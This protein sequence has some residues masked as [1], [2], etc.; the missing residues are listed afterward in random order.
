MQNIT[1]YTKLTQKIILR[2]LQFFSIKMNIGLKP[3]NALV[4][5]RQFTNSCLQGC[6]F[7]Y[8]DYG[9]RIIKRVLSSGFSR[10]MFLRRYWRTQHLYKM[11]KQTEQFVVHEI[12]RSLSSRER[13]FVKCVAFPLTSSITLQQ[14]SLTLQSA[15]DTAFPFQCAEYYA[16]IE[17]CLK[18]L[19]VCPLTMS[20][21]FI[22]CTLIFF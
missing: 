13:A 18:H 5:S 4:Q 3:D 20:F 9:R 22:L 10:Y 6:N 21:Q 2:I 1:D 14:R 12:K 15:N 17:Y 19:C 8:V 11:K 7:Y 16:S